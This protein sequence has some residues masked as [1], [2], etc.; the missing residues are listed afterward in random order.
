MSEH[1]ELAVAPQDEKWLRI[2][3]I[4]DRFEEA[5]EQGKR[6]ALSE[7]L[8]EGADLL[9]ELLVELIHV[10]LEFRLQAGEA[11]RVE[12]YL[13]RYP[14]LADERQAVLALIQTEWQI[15][16]ARLEPQ[17]SV[18]EYQQRFPALAQELN[19]VLCPVSLERQPDWPPTLDTHKHFANP[20][21]A[22][23]S[24]PHRSLLT[25]VSTS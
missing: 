23:V 20:S 24:P 14:E 6:P 4:A 19:K 15:R 5:W 3:R 9:P 22:S 7:Y 1:H 18:Q 8:R 11:A 2:D 13:T 12:E 17:L 10:E 16:R 25:C 21:S